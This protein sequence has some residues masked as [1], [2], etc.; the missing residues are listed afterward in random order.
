LQQLACR[1][2]SKGS[3]NMP[4][5]H[6][7]MRSIQWSCSAAHPQL[8]VHHGHHLTLLA[9]CRTV[10][11]HMY[12]T[13]EQVCV[14]MV[15]V[16]TVWCCVVWRVCLRG[17]C[18]CCCSTLVGDIAEVKAIKKVFTDTTHVKMNA[19]KSLI[20]HCLGAA[21][22]IEAVAVV[23]AIQ[24]GWLHPTLNQHNLVEEVAGIDTVPFEK[25]QHK[26]GSKAAHRHAEVYQ[27]TCC[28][29]GRLVGHKYDIG[30]LIHD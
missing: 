12:A 2:C 9:E 17:M 21:A 13:L 20:G 16:L 28:L 3:K 4:L 27:A 30:L 19:T 8:V 15:L 24:T 25:K 1:A 10:K 18:G 22:G 5:L 26:V 29:V 14:N 7:N 11:E 23:K 6:I